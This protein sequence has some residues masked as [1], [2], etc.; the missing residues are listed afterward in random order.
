MKKWARALVFLVFV[1]IKGDF[2]RTYK[3]SFPKIAFCLGSRQ[4]WQQWISDSSG[5]PH[6]QQ[7][8]AD[9]GGQRHHSSQQDPVARQTWLRLWVDTILIISA[10]LFTVNVF[11]IL[12]KK[13]YE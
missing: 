10:K 7:V 4:P 2:F 1:L 6:L 12:L 8:Q 5:V 11:T 9:Q 3:Y 13:N